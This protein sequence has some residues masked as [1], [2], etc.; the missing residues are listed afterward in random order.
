MGRRKIPRHRDAGSLELDVEALGALMT[1]ANE[2]VLEHLRTL[3]TQPLHAVAGGKKLAA[4]LAEPMPE[5]GAPIERLLKQLF[6]RVIPASL[7]T[8]SPGYLAYIPGGGLPE[9]AIADMIALATNRYVGVW[10]AAPG[11]VQLEKNVIDWFAAVV[12]LPPSTSGG[13]LVSGG[14]LANLVAVT[15]ARRERLPTNFLGGRLYTSTEAHHSVVKAAILAGFP[16]E[17][18]AT[19]RVDERFRVDIGEL[20]QSIARDREAGHTPFMVIGHGGTTNTGAVDDLE[21]LARVAKREALWFHVDAAYGGFF[22]LTERGRAKLR[23]IERADSVTLDPHKGLFMP[24][25]TGCVLVRDRESL[26]RTHSVHASYMPP[27][28]DEP[29]LLDFCE[30]GPELSREARGL[31]MWLPLKLHGASAF[32][33][34]LDEKLDL[35]LAAR[36]GLAAM[37]GIEIVAEPELSLFAFRHVPDG[38]TEGAAL[39]SHNR[40]LLSKINAKQ[41][42]FLTGATSRG[43]YFIRVAVLSFRTHRDRIDALLED[44]ASALE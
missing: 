4:A 9:A 24:Y 22:A 42:V 10:Q 21:A 34:A 33:R 25:G 14:S 41:R 29:D 18:V 36:D 30:M 3:P 6:G 8:A 37:S 2:R 35:A 26:R 20:E 17:N 13:L 39:E 23:G 44:V 19:I 11:L 31:R 40:A 28:Q 38:V 15:T 7:N 16:P 32:R 27:M 43:R 1:T 5:R 12:G